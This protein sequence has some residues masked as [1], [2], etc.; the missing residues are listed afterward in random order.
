MN[1]TT[2]GDLTGRIDPQ[3][4]ACALIAVKARVH[5]KTRLSGSLAPLARVHHRGRNRRHGALGPER[6][7][8]DCPGR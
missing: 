2:L 3:R 5:C 4:G 7:I 6:R 8:R 1:L